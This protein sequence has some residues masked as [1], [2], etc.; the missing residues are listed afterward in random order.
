MNPFHPDDERH[1]L[2]E[3][4]REQQLPLQIVPVEENEEIIPEAILWYIPRDQRN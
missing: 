4:L 3:Q 2:W 1:Q